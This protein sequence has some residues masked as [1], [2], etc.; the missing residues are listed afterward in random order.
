M[1][2][3]EDLPLGLISSRIPLDP[4]VIASFALPKPCDVGPAPP[5]L[6]CDN[7]AA[8]IYGGLV[9]TGRFR[10]HELPE[11]PQHRRFPRTQP[12]H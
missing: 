6:R 3:N 1:P 7:P 9:E 12:F 5:P 11:K 4:Q 8:A 2:E 10:A